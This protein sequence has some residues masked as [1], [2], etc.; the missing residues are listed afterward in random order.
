MKVL[1][2]GAAGQLGYALQQTAPRYWDDNTPVQ[3]LP[4]TRATFDLSKADRLAAQL[5]VYRP[6]AII[7]AGAYTAVDKAEADEHQA[8]RI[9]AHAVDAIARWCQRHKAPLVQISTDFVFD[10]KKSSPYLPDDQPN[11]MGVYARTKRAG[12]INALNNCDFAYVVRTGWIYGEYGTNFVKTMLRLAAER[13]SLTV[14]SDQVGTPSYAINLAQMVWQ[15][16]Q[17]QPVQRIFHY[18]DA[19]V[20]SWYDFAVAI[21]YE[22]YAQGILHNLP[23]VIPINTGDYPTP[24]QRPAYS[25]LD[26]Q[27]TWSILDI[28]ACHWRLGLIAMLEA[29]KKAVEL[30]MWSG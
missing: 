30:H 14:V 22:A 5:D 29:Y 3:L 16:L 12:E 7:N 24:V 1:I 28:E 4:M 20:A 26:K 10:G 21:V 23:Q 13:D 27:A 18:S 15:L 2:T 11:P 17:R 9:N 8:E 19:G 25:V 6:D